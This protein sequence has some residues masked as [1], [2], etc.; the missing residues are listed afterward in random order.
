MI[1][2]LYCFEW[3]KDSQGCKDSCQFGYDTACKDR[4]RNDWTSRPKYY[5]I[6]LECS[7][8]KENV[9]IKGSTNL[10]VIRSEVEDDGSITVVSDYW[11]V[12]MKDMKDTLFLVEEIGQAKEALSNAHKVF[13]AEIEDLHKII[14]DQKIAIKILEFIVRGMNK[15]MRHP[16]RRPIPIWSGRPLG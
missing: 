2:R 4:C 7:T 1:E 8:T 6:K 14:E 12:K 9:T 3:C 10:N 16:T 11:P 13:A 15:E 5:N